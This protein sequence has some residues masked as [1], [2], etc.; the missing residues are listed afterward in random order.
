MNDQ[1]EKSKEVQERLIHA[2]DQMMERAKEGLKDLQEDTQPKLEKALQAAKQKA[3][4]LK[5]IT[6]EEAEEVTQYVKRDLHDIADNVK[7][8]GREISDWLR[9]DTLIAESEI[10]DRLSTLTERAKLEINHLKNSIS[11]Y[12][13]WHTG[14][15]T[16][17]GTL[18]CA[19]CGKDLHFNKTGHIPP[20]PSCHATVFKRGK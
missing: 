8:Q 19:K 11:R 9:L 6:R 12:D 15:I 3:M 4:E 2:Y 13:E 16:G 14:E 18:Q 10:V 7:Q 1:K 5:E 20:C 17:I